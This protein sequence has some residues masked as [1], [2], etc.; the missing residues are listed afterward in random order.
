[1]Q[2][3]VERMFGLSNNLSGI[4]G[5]AITSE[6]FRNSLQKEW[7]IHDL[8]LKNLKLISDINF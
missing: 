5:E 8:Y 2:F 1:M 3:E 7:S 4:L 6:L